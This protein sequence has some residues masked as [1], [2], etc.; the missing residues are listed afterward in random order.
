MASTLDIA[1][2]VAK[3]ELAVA[4]QRLFVDRLRHNNAVLTCAE[5]H[6]RLLERSLG[7]LT[8]SYGTL[9]RFE[10]KARGRV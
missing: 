10:A 2:S 8:A 7:R 9:S 3:V 4:R 6:L 1:R 5:D